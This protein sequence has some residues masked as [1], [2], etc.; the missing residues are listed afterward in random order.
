MYTTETVNKA[1]EET[2]KFC[3]VCGNQ[4]PMGLACSAI[5]CSKC[6]RD[7]CEQC[8]GHEENTSGDYRW[9]YCIDCW[10]IGKPHLSNIE[11]LS[12]QIEKEH[13]RWHQ[14]CLEHLNNMKGD[15]NG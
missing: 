15:I 11:L 14:K 12:N 1:V 5:K 9:G 2:H 10:E 8:V 3:D 13:T 6:K 4:I 7:L